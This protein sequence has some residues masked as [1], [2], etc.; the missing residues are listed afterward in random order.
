M[1]TILTQSPTRSSTAIQHRLVA[2]LRKPG[3][4]GFRAS[5]AYV[6]WGGLGALANGL[7]DLLDAGG[8]VETIFG[9]DNGVTSPDALLY[10]VYLKKRYG[11]RV[12]AGVSDWNYSNSIFHPKYYEF[13]FANRL[14]AVV[15]S[16]NLTGGGLRSN[17]ELAAELE[18]SLQSPLAMELKGIWASHL[19]LAIPISPKLISKLAADK[20][21]A[22]EATAEVPPGR[23]RPRLKLPK[24]PAIRA[25]LF[26]RVLKKGRARSPVPHEFLAEAADLSQKPR[27]LFLQILHETGGGHQVQLPV[28]TLGAFF[29]V[30]PGQ[31]KEVT[32]TFSPSEQVTVHL[33]HFPNNTHRVRL[34]PI[35]PVPRPFVLI[36]TRKSDTHYVCTVVPRTEYRR[37]LAKKCTEQTRKGSRRWGLST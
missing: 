31:S 13:R 34:L 30:G 3:L 4:L 12:Y 11:S 35:R 10:A 2:L 6:R 32:F 8:K 29:G 14:V 33:T 20:Q 27:R 21:L 23:K 22:D 9:I 1:P 24:F 37:V 16:A 26:E 18:A 19:R 7:E 28:A 25:P 36:F 5:V 15:G 17:H